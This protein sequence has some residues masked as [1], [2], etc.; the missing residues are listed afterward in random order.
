MSEFSMMTQG[1]TWPLAYGALAVAMVVS[2]LATWWLLTRSSK[3][4]GR[5]R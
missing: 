5:P 1:V 4:W 3:A 2:G